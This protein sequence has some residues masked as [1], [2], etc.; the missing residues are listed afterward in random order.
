MKGI[1]LNLSLKENIG[2]AFN[3]IFKLKKSQQ[4]WGAVRKVE[5][6][7]GRIGATHFVRKL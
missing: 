1:W 2:L 7:F 5:K 6:R 4:M 3:D